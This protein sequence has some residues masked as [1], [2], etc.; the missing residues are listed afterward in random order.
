MARPEELQPLLGPPSAAGPRAAAA[1]AAAVALLALVAG[2]AALGAPVAGAP[3]GQ[4]RG[5]GP[6]W[7]A[8]DGVTKQLCQHYFGHG[9]N[10][11]ERLITVVDVDVRDG[12]P[13]G[14]MTMVH[15]S[16]P[17]SACYSPGPPSGCHRYIRVEYARCP[18]LSD[19]P[20]G[21]HVGW[22]GALDAR[23]RFSRASGALRA[24]EG[25]VAARAVTCWGPPGGQP[26]P[27]NCP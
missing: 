25:A 8:G 23:G 16:G 12:Y 22:A 27:C 26:R 17:Y 10:S 5:G 11:T 13:L 2:A 6:A 20:G 15:H 19:G 1:A 18:A 9:V 24:C 7:A 3:R 14:N 21:A 4:A